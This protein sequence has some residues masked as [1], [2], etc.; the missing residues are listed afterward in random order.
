[1]GNPLDSNIHKGALG[2]LLV[3]VKLL[4]LN[5]ESFPP[6]KDS[7]TDL[8]AYIGKSF[9]A[10]QVKTKKD[11]SSWRVPQRKKLY[12]ILAL[13]DL[14]QELLLDQSGIWL[15]TKEEAEENRK[16]VIEK[17]NSMQE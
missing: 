9:K 8:V 5:I 16:K 15:L 11:G 3:Q 2:K 1:M 14:N 10:I 6:L 12:D 4:T 13:V 7:G 17:T